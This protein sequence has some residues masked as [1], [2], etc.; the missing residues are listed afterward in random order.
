MRRSR[1][2]TRA[3]SRPS[4][5]SRCPLRATGQQVTVQ[6]ATLDGSAQAG[7]DYQSDSGTLTFEPDET[8]KTIRITILGDGTI[9]AGSFFFVQLSQPIKATIANG[10]GMAKIQL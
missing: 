5:S 2:G 1:K 3:R 10:R 4:S 7:R 9:T 8:T 6:D